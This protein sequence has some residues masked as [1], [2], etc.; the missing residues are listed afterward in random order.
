LAHLNSSTT[1]ALQQLSQTRFPDISGYVPG[2]D[3]DLLRILR[4]VPFPPIVP[5]SD[6]EHRIRNYLPDPEIRDQLLYLFH[7]EIGDSVMTAFTREYVQDT[8]I[9]RAL[10]G[11]GP[12]SL[13]ALGTLFSL[14]AIGA[15]FAV[16]GPGEAVQVN[17]YARISSIAVGCVGPLS[18]ALIDV[19]EATFARACLE[20]FRQ[21]PWEE[22]ARTSLALT[23]H[24]CFIVSQC[25]SCHNN[26]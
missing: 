7:G 11:E 4:Q 12:R 17:H 16:P 19:I 21:G 1:D 8:V 18:T 23:C 6:P 13:A 5:L 24:R 15:L 26:S 10:R 3:P 9:P 22:P 25:I 2:I 20:L 14:M